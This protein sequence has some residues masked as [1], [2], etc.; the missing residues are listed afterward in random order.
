MKLEGKPVA[1]KILSDVR[2]EVEKLGFEPG[3]SIVRVGNDPASETYV[4]TKLKRATEVGIKGTEHHLDEKTTEKELISLVRRINGD[5]GVDGVIVQLPLPPHINAENVL[6]EILPGK[7]VDGLHPENLGKLVAGEP[8][9]IPA[10]PQGVMEL[11]SYYKI[12]PAGKTAVVV[13]RSNMVGKPMAALLL[14]A[15]ASVEICHS[16]TPNLAEHTKRA[17]ILVVAVGK[18]NLIT[19]EMVREGAAVIDVGINRVEGKIVGDVDFEKVSK[20]ARATPVPGGVGLLTVACLMK[21]VLKA[22]QEKR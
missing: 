3:L 2:E 5:P 21:N 13:G 9:F 18:P 22:A 12:N 6:G 15:D 7:D 17:E 8:A 14:N 11:L 16:K 1:E 19:A 10:T 20:K 4:K